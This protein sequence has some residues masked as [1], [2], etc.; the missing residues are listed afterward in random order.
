[1]TNRASGNTASSASSH[2]RCDGH[3]SRHGRPA[4]SPHCRSW[5]DP[6]L[7][8]VGRREVGVEQPVVVRRAVGER[9]E[10]VGPEVERHQLLALHRTRSATSGTS[11]ASRGFI[12]SCIAMFAVVVAILGSGAS[13]VDGGGHGWPDSQRRSDRALGSSARRNDSAVEPVRGSPRP[14]SGAV[15]GSSAISG[16]RRYQSS[17]SRRDRSRRPTQHREHDVAQLVERRLGG[18]R[19]HESVEALPERVVAEV[20]QPRLVGGC[21]QQLVNPHRSP[22]I[23]D[24]TLPPNRGLHVTRAVRGAR[25]AAPVDAELGSVSSLRTPWLGRSSDEFGPG[26]PSHWYGNRAH[27][28]VHDDRGRPGGGVRGAGR[29]VGPRRYRRHRLGARVPGR[30]SHHRRRPGVPDGD[31]PREPPGQGLRDRQ[32]GRGVRRAAGHRVEARAGVARDRGTQLRRLD[33]A[34]RPRGDR[35]VADDGDADVRLVSGPAPTS[36]ST[37]SSRRSGRTTSTTRCSTC[38]T[39]SP[40]SVRPPA[41]RAGR[42]GAPSPGLPAALP[43]TTAS[44]RRAPG[45]A[46]A[47]RRPNHDGRRRGWCSSRPCRLPRRAGGGGARCRG[48]PSSGA[49]GTSGGPAAAGSGSGTAWIAVGP[50]GNLWFT[51]NGGNKVARIRLRVLPSDRA[52]DFDGDLRADIAVYRPAT[53]SLVHP[54]I[55]HELHDLHPAVSGARARI[56]RSPG[57]YDGDGKT[58]IAVYRPSTGDVVGPGVAHR[59]SGRRVHHAAVGPAHG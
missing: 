11:A 37:S 1:M 38:P 58:D 19:V 31:V 47:G 34:L 45:P 28:R 42:R 4:G 8:A 25:G 27:D 53:G 3:F 9:R 48:A 16:W 14:I 49:R 43:A 5:S 20:R 23:R 13:T 50:D 10:V 21:R 46:R 39:S 41:A 40:R 35:P 55:E 7:V 26:E 30:R 24:R 36:A 33:L 56:F 18:H 59:T 2:S 52:A 12:S 29:P 32:P 54:A 17:T 57:D 51:E 6:P 15:M 22:R 44:R